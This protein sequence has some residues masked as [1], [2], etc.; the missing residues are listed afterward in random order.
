MFDWLF[1]PR[2]PVDAEKKAWIEKRMSWLTRQF[3][4]ERLYDVRVILPTP[5]FFPDPYNGT[6]EDAMAIFRRVCGYMKLDPD[7]FKLRF[8]SDQH[9]AAGM[10]LGGPVSHQGS[11]GQYERRA[12]EVIKIELKGLQDPLALIAT[13]AHELSHGHLL[14]DRR[15]SS[16]EKDHEPL[17]DLLTVFLGMGIFTS[18][19]FIRESSDFSH[20]RI[21]RQGY[22]TMPMYGYALALF[23]WVRGEAK[24]AWA[25]YLRGDVYAPFKHGLRYLVKTGDSQFKP[26]LKP[27]SPVESESEDE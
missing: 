20:Y 9:P 8:Y 2:C 26:M 12:M 11:A 1:P 3:G 19:S 17:T 18:N 25:K 27:H 22:L 4:L 15:I 5:E 6:K 23:A 16:E 21:S 10:A 7:R 13:M 24:P 14:G